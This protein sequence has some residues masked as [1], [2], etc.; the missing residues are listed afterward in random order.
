MKNISKSID[1][2]TK[3]AYGGECGQDAAKHLIK[4]LAEYDYL[5]GKQCKCTTKQDTVPKCGT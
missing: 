1:F 3:Y 4:L 2:L 5:V